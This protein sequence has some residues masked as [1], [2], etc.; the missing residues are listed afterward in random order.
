MPKK[1][2]IFTTYYQDLD[3]DSF[4]N[5]DSIIQSC[6]LVAPMGYVTNHQD[7]DDTNENINPDAEEACDGLDNDCDNEADNGLEIF[8][9]YYDA[10]QDTYGTGDEFIETCEDTPPMGY[11]TNDF[12]CDDFNNTINPDT[13]EIPNNGIDEDCINGDLI[14]AV[15]E[16][17]FDER[18]DL[19]PNP[20]MDQLTIRSEYQ[21]ELIIQILSGD[22]KLI[23]KSSLLLENGS[24][25]IDLAEMPSGIYFVVISNTEGTKRHF[26]K[27]AKVD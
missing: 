10:D 26:Q 2:A 11:V 3:N 18:I 24:S 17:D 13:E 23:S 7:C 6:E 8:T 16:N 19:F 9:Y 25:S 15:E 20:F 14:I 22:G 12:D 27:V 1:R 4:G 21:G 5:P